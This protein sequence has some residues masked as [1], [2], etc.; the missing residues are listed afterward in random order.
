[1]EKKQLPKLSDLYANDSLLEISKQD[2][3]NFLLN[4]EPKNTWVKQ[5][6]FANNSNYIPIGIIETLL[7][8]IYKQTKIEIL[9]CKAVF[10][11]CVVTV[12]LHY[13]NPVVNEW[14]WQDG[15]GAVELQT[16]KDTG[17]LKTDFSNI[18]KGA[19]MMAFPMA[20][21]FAIKDA[22]EH[23]GKLFG[24]D[25]NR[26]DVIEYKP[27]EITYDWPMIEELFVLKSESL[28]PN[29]YQ[30]CRRIIDEKEVKSF[31]KLYKTLQN[32]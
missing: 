10:N 5:N 3:L 14:S 8:K 18:N 21:S 31:S 29:E 4:Q 15:I 30:D 32:K 12:R 24:R 25:I 6:P 1:M 9:D 28:T 7:Q 17:V 20:K 13:Y 26:K 2:D 19:V 16:K 11:A 22:A 23:L 27:D